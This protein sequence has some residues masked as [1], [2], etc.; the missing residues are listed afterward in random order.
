M[1]M[2]ICKPIIVGVPN[3]PTYIFP[4]AMVSCQHS[5]LLGE[6]VSIFTHNKRKPLSLFMIIFHWMDCAATFYFI[7]FVALAV[8]NKC[9]RRQ[10]QVEHGDAGIG[11]SR[12]HRTSAHCSRKTTALFIVVFVAFITGALSRDNAGWVCSNGHPF[13]SVFETSNYVVFVVIFNYQVISHCNVVSS[14]QWNNV[15][16]NLSVV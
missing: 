9:R 2:L 15:N 1:R 4:G 16:Y 11:E 6:H 5:S 10:R 7:I 3:P 14:W 8:D 13:V 12:Q